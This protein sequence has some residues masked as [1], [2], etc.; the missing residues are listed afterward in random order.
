MKRLVKHDFVEPEF[1]RTDDVPGLEVDRL[2]AVDKEVTEEETAGIDRPPAGRASQGDWGGVHPREH[3]RGPRIV[4][5]LGHP[6]R[7]QYEI[8]DQMP[9]Q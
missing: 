1:F 7:L 3:K 8:S 9:D 4:F 2:A 6:G 5:S